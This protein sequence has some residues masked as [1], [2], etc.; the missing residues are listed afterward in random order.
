MIEIYNADCLE[1]LKN[2]PDN[3]VDLVVTDPPYVLDNHGGGAWKNRKHYTE[4]RP[5]SDGFS[6]EILDE[7]CRV[8]KKINCYFFC[9]LKQIVQLHDYFVNKRKC[10]WNLLT[11]HKTNPIPACNNRY[12]NDTEFILFF[13]EKGVEIHGTYDTKKTYYVTPLNTKD[14]KLYNHPTCKPVEIL[15][16]LILNSSLE[17][18]IVLDPFMGSGSTGVACLN[19]NRHFIGIELDKKYFE[20]AKERLESVE[21][22]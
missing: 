21:T 15:Q 4:I 18:E 14:K 7:L 11:W 2:I 10:Y 22:W 19:T 17:N 8:M 5:L 16:N 9:S 6:D 20:I 3:S 13:R 1:K 12:I